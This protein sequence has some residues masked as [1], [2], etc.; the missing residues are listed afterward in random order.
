MAL[1]EIDRENY[2]EL[3]RAIMEGNSCLLECTDAA[4]GEKRAIIC[5]V[6][7]DGEEMAFVPFAAMAH[8]N[9][10]EL[11]IPPEDEVTL[12]ESNEEGNAA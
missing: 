2:R 8:D 7:R 9:P 12:D 3:C 10:Y 1:S 4:S 6:I 11:W 5:A